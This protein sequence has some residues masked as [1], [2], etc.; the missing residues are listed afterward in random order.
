LS[1]FLSS[2]T[3]AAFGNAP[4]LLLNEEREDSGS[5]AAQ[6]LRAI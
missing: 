1:K 4:S 2:P 6:A 3:A 5:H